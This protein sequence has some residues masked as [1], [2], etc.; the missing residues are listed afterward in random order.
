MANRCRGIFSQN[1]SGEWI[2]SY[3]VSLVDGLG[4]GS[5][6]DYHPYSNEALLRHNPYR[7]LLVSCMKRKTA[8]PHVCGELPEGATDPKCDKEEINIF[9]SQ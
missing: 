1:F 4:G 6:G 3:D 2:A 7:G 8:D 9:H 5:L